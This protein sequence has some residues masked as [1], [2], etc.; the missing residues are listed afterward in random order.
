MQNEK[1]DERL[2]MQAGHR[3]PPTTPPP[4]PPPPPH[5]HPTPP[6]RAAE[7]AEARVQE[8]T[9]G[10]ENGRRRRRRCSSRER[11][12]KEGLIQEF[13][14]TQA[15]E[16]DVD[17][18]IED[19]KEK[20]ETNWRRSARRRL[21]KA[22]TASCARSSPRFKGHRGPEGEIRQFFNNKHAARAHRLAREGHRRPE[23]EIRER[24]ETSATRRSGST[25]SRRIR[26]SRSSS[27]CSTTRSR[28][29]RSRSSRARSRSWR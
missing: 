13:E 26:S 9:D 12:E 2:G 6:P 23:K 15:L 29:S 3:H 17:R 14:E 24:D 4:P 8:L 25:T 7:Q 22:R 28:S 18:E 1:W 19:L 11:G 21:S 5:H 10:Y 20:Y 27:S 16:E